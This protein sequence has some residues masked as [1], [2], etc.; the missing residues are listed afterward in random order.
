MLLCEGDP[1]GV[2][3]VSHTSHE[4]RC[5]RIHEID[6]SISR[7]AAP[8]NGFETD[9]IQCYCTSDRLI[10]DRLRFFCWCDSRG[11]SF[12]S[13]LDGA[14][15]VAELRVGERRYMTDAVASLRRPM[16][17]GKPL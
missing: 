4:G 10:D 1:A 15:E 2:P 6:D 11:R 13:C 12:A 8:Q 7:N 17:Q 9:W 16:Q 3:F 14:N 5:D